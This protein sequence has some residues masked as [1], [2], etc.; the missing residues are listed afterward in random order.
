MPIEISARSRD[1]EHN[2]TTSKM[3]SKMW[4]HRDNRNNK[5]QL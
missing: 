1:V 5:C 2:V 3:S 4:R